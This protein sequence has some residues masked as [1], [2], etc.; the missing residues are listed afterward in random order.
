M[1]NFA[2]HKDYMQYIPVQIKVFP[3]SVYMFNPGSLPEDWTVSTLFE[4][5]GS[6]PHNPLLAT[7]IFRTG[8]IE[9]WGRGIE[10]IVDGCNRIGAPL[11]KFETM[12]GDMSIEFFAP[13]DAIQKNTADKSPI[14]GDKLDVNGHKPTITDHKPTIS[15][16]ITNVTTHK[17]P[18]SDRAKAVLAFIDEHNGIANSDAQKLLGIGRSMVKG[19]FKEM[20]AAK[21]IIAI[22]EK[23]NRFY[24]RPKTSEDDRLV[25]TDESV[26]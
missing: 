23:K 26:R 2:Y 19:L 16:H 14:S 18:K 10:K 17:V 22:G 7:T 12:G 6:R 8:M 3:D 24:R 1:Y 9:T 4:K 21:Q 5:H 11:P 15:D 25:S 13:S 20:L